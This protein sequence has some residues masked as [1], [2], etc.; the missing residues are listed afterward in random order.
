MSSDDVKNAKISSFRF[1]KFSRRKSTAFQLHLNGLYSETGCIPEGGPVRCL[2]YFV[3][4]LCKSYLNYRTS[5]IKK[6]QLV[7]NLFGYW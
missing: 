7:C 1:G 5:G 2:S 3:H 6:V 4:S